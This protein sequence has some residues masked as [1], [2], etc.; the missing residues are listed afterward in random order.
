ML[1]SI[2]EQIRE[3]VT[4]ARWSLQGAEAVIKRRSLRASGDF[5][6]YWNFHEEQEHLR[7]HYSQYAAP[8]I[9]NEL[10]RWDVKNKVDE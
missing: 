8:S 6:S 2:K 1:S 7:N 3:D 9:I 10:L 5:D 4:G